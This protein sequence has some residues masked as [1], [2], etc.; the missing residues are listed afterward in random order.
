MTRAFRRHRVE[1]L[2]VLATL[3][4]GAFTL[5]YVFT[6][7]EARPRFPWEATP[8]HLAAEFQNSQGAVP[9]QGQSVRVA[10]VQ[11]GLVAGVKLH[12][13]TALVEMDL[14]PKYAHYLHTDAS[15]LLRPHTVLKDQFVEVDPG[16]AQAPYLPSGGTI[17]LRRTEPDVN[18]DEINAALDSDSRAYLTL[19]INGLGKGLDHRGTDLRQVLKIYKPLHRSLYQVSHAVATN[20]VQLARLI[21]N[22]RVLTEALAD[23]DHDL[24]KFVVQGNRFFAATASQQAAIRRAVGLFPSAL[25][26]TTTSLVKSAALARVST[27]VLDALR[28]ALGRDLD[29]ANKATVPLVRKGTPILRDRVRPF[30][31]RTTPYIRTL[32][33]GARPFKRALPDLTSSFKEINRLLNILANNPNGAE[34][35]TGDRAKDRAREEGYLY[36]LAWGAHNTNSVESM[37]DGQGVLR[38]V[39]QMFS[40]DVVRGMGDSNPALLTI[41]NLDNLVDDPGFCPK[42]R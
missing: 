42:P 22:Y 17:P 1:L 36:W 40:C 30:V 2:M 18:P 11:I 39:V 28:P 14:D 23:K 34:R 38:R 37:S 31:R 35:L 20:H 5:M 3:I 4:V 8:F 6:H 29:K 21:H 19:L 7:E 33:R 9:G 41:L 24:T 25:S 13:G 26:H 15:A 27:P 12:S 16:T 10:G 32:E